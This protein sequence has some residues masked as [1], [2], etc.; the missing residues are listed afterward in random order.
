MGSTLLVGRVLLT[1]GEQIR[2]QL[3]INAFACLFGLSVLLTSS[4][5]A[6]TSG[7]AIVPFWQ[8]SSTS[9]TLIDIVNVSSASVNVSVTLYKEN[10]GT[11][12]ESTEGGTNL[13]FVWGFA[14]QDPISSS[15]TLASQADGEIAILCGGTSTGGYA[16]INWTSDS[17]VPTTA[18]VATQRTEYLTSNCT[19]YTGVG[20][21]PINNGAPF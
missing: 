20:I 4:A 1:I 8:K 12:T 10:V 15:A 2:V 6:D 19:A 18:L 11:Y 13:A 3:F 21:F 5:N 17:D 16:V 14:S 7:K 9:K